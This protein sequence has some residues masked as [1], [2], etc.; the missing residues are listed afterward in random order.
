MIVEGARTVGFLRDVNNVPYVDLQGTPTAILRTVSNNDE[1]GDG[2]LDEDGQTSDGADVL[3]PVIP[4]GISV[5]ASAVAPKPVTTRV[6]I[7]HGKNMAIVDQIKTMLNVAEVEYEIAAE[8]ESTAI[9]VSEKVFDAMRNC[10]A[11]VICVTA[12]DVREGQPIAIN[13]NVLIEIGAAFVLYEKRVI[14]L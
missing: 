2:N 1:N 6:F 14:L 3:A 10:T 5:V 8:S 12:D 11:A 7:S 13:Q 4:R 9:P